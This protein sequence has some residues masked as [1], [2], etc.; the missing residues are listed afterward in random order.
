MGLEVSFRRIAAYAEIREQRKAEGKTE[1]HLA[2]VES[3]SS[4]AQLGLGVGALCFIGSIMAFVAHRRQ[5]KAQKEPIQSS[6]RMPLTR[7][8]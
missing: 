1:A 4:A 5:I 6:Q 8:G 7:H 2:E 3:V